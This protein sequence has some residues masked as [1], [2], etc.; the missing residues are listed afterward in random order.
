MRIVI[1]ALLLAVAC[2][3]QPPPA[4]A[5]E[6]GRLQTAPGV[7]LF[8]EKI[9]AGPQVVI[10]P[11]RLFLAD[12]FRELASADRTIILYDMRNRGASARVE[13]GALL[14]IIE[15]VRDLEAVRAHFG[16]ERF[17]PIG[18]SYLGVM[19]A[20]YAAEHPERVERLV[21]IGPAPR[22]FDTE[23]PA[24]ETAGEDTLPPEA[25]AARDLARQ[26]R[27][28]E[29]VTQQQMCAD[30]RAFSAYVLVGDPANRGRLM[31][32]C[33]HENE[34]PE[35]LIRHFGFH[36]ADIQTR[37]FPAETFTGLDQPTL[38]VH[39][40]LDRNAPYGAGREWARTFPDA[41]L[42]TVEGGAH[43]VWADDP[44]V[45]EAID[46]FLEGEWPERAEAID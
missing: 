37:D 38:V 22:D 31:D 8:Y 39:G 12:S 30:E 44:R 19:T 34:W 32:P 26:R 24:Q 11:G 13:D 36:F 17:T 23:Y 5:A 16:A 21:Q 33:Q 1:A 29:G 41:R 4:P 6:T 43:A 2:T 28:V 7:T 35:S 14:N 10:I 3:P 15:D 25:F 18:F 42:I 27:N 40:T 45:V 46:A 9:G 20:L